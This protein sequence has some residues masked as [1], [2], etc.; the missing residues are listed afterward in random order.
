M[1]ALLTSSK[2]QLVE[3]SNEIISYSNESLDRSYFFSDLS[4]GVIEVEA[5]YYIF[6][7]YEYWRNIFHTWFGLCIL[8]SGDSADT[9]TSDTVKELAHHTRIEMKENHTAMYKNFMSQLNLC[10]EKRIESRAT[11]QYRAHFINKFGI[12]NG[13]FKEAVAA[14]SGRELFASIRNIWVK[15]AFKTHYNIDK[16]PWWDIHEQLELDHFHD[17]FAPLAGELADSS[18]CEEVMRYMV[19]EIDAHVHYWDQLYDE[20]LNLFPI[21]ENQAGNS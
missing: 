6:Q 3:I 1:N 5:L 7:Q 20:A 14:L 4:K 15:K 21:I 2:K 10:A 18:R 11:K 13:N 12:T 9:Y 8:K 17:T 16:T 19:E